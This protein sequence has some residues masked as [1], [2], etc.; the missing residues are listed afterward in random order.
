MIDMM[1]VLSIFKNKTYCLFV[2]FI[3][4]LSTTSCTSIGRIISTPNY[5]HHSVDKILLDNIKEKQTYSVYIKSA[6]KDDIGYDKACEM[7]SGCFLTHKANKQIVNLFD[8]ADI[9]ITDKPEKADYIISV[10]VRNVVD[11]LDADYAKKMR[12]AFLQYG[13]IGDYMFDKNNNP[14]IFTQ[15]KFDV[16]KDSQ[17]SGIFISRR[18]SILPSVL[19]TFIGAGAGFVA[20][21]FIGSV[22]PIAIGFAGALL[23]GGL[24]Y[25]VYSSF[26]DVGVAVVYDISISK[27]LNQTIKQN[28]KSVVKLS[29]NVSEEHYYTLENDM[30]KYMSR[31]AI[32]AIGSKAIKRDMLLRIST[33]MANSVADTFGV[34]R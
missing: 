33:M 3:L 14:H 17:N 20:G 9:S 32:I 15:Q 4:S 24:T 22:S 13:V 29:G 6:N 1:F 31:N 12:N 7:D 23:V 8:N 16:S 25:A 2:L 19:Y 34:K 30:E 10:D 28:R 27:K 26:K 21:Y 18:K 11:E 5:S